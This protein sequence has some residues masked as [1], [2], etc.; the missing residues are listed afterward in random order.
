MIKTGKT[1]KVTHKDKGVC[2]CKI[3]HID[4]RA[5]YGT[6]LKYDN[7]MFPEAPGDDIRITN[8]SKIE[9]IK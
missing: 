8:K 2:L 7:P 3:R 5:T 4:K 9:E 6:I 1:Y